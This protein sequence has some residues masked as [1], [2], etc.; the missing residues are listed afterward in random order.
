METI[1]D[2]YSPEDFPRLEKKIK[3]ERV[4][5]IGGAGLTLLVCVLLCC[6]TTAANWR[7]TEPA[8][9][10]VSTLGGWFTI[11]R[12]LFGWKE[13]RSELR[14]AQH[15]REEPRQLLRGVLTVTKERL[16]IKNSIRIR[17]LR[18]DDG[19][20]VHRVM[21]NETRVKALKDYD[22]REVTLSMAGSYLA[23]IGGSDADL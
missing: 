10:A 18:L 11:Y 22:G 5:V 12:R 21:V 16:R 23:G 2:L 15:L 3:R 4:W 20:T 1:R 9:I 17:I 14:H 13:S 19:E 8:V 6:F 7:Q